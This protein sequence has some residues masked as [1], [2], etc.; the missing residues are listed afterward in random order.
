MIEQQKKT[1]GLAKGGQPYR[2]GS[3]GSIWDPVAIPTL[4][5]AG[6]D[7]KLAHRARQLAVVPKPQFESMI[8]DW[9]ERVA[10]ETER[11]TTNLVREGSRQQ[12]ADQRPHKALPSGRYSLIY[13]DPPWRYEGSASESRAIENQYPTMELEQ[14]A[15]LQICDLAA[16]DCVLL[17]WAPPPKLEEALQVLNAWGF[18][19]RT[20]G[21]WDKGKIGLGYWFRQQHELLLVGV[22]GEPKPPDPRNRQSSIVRAVR[23]GHSEKPVEVYILIEKMFPKYGAR[24]RIELFSRSRRAGWTMWGNEP[25]GTIL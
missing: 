24:E 1:V 21:V 12:K 9:R 19:Y 3:T 25:D 23:K 8:G 18:Q 7:K 5:E 4:A 11:L 16:D 2:R 13:A 10:D 20:C 6:I 15:A 22:R 14:I 17:L